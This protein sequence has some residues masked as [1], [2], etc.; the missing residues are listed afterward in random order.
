MRSYDLLR[1]TD[2]YTSG[3]HYQLPQCWSSALALAS[4]DRYCC[5]LALKWSRGNALVIQAI[6]SLKVS[7]WRL[8]RGH[9]S[10][11]RSY[12]GSKYA[13]S[14]RLLCGLHLDLHLVAKTCQSCCCCRASARHLTVTS[15]YFNA[16][17]PRLTSRLVCLRSCLLGSWSVAN[18]LIFARHHLRWTC[19]I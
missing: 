10:L 3:A 13:H 15:G 4:I 14:K 11:V 8:A 19:L 12:V 2:H 5:L 7:I 1:H 16:A 9:P 18:E 6:C 17:A